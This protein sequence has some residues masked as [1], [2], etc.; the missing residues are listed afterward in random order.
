MSADQARSWRR[1]LTP[2][3][4]PEYEEYEGEGVRHSP[5]RGGSVGLFIAPWRGGPDVLQSVIP[6]GV[7][8]RPPPLRSRIYDG[9]RDEAIKQ[10][11][12]RPTF[13]R[14]RIDGGYVLQAA[15]PFDAL[16]IM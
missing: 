16:G 15:L 9:R 2:A 5:R 3:L 6:P 10:V 11:P 14:T 13:E 7:D 8:P 4:S 1:P 12:P